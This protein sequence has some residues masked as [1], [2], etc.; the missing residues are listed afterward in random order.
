ML[1]VWIPVWLPLLVASVWGW[2]RLRR[3]IRRP[4]A[5]KPSPPETA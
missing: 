4:I 2:R 5:P 3:L 1:L